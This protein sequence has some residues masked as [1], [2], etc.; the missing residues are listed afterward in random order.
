[1]NHA[2]QSL[3]RPLELSQ[4]ITLQAHLLI[5]SILSGSISLYTV[6]N[7]EDVRFL[8]LSRRTRAGL[9]SPSPA[10][11]FLTNPKNP[12]LKKTSPE[13][14]DLKNHLP[15]FNFFSSLQTTIFHGIIPHIPSRLAFQPSIK[16][17]RCG[18]L[19]CSP[20]DVFLSRIFAR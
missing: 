9:L 5:I 19:C 16:H 12:G 1:M 3:I 13:P 4:S 8:V 6:L 14:Q 18:P 15:V 10:F 2:T 17:H 7:Q 11:S 20:S